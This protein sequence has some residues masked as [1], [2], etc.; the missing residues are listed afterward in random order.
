LNVGFFFYFFFSFPLRRLD[1]IELAPRVASFSSFFLFLLRTFFFFLSW[2]CSLCGARMWPEPWDRHVPFF[3]SFFSFGLAAQRL[4]KPDIVSTPSSP[5]RTG[6]FRSAAYACGLS[7]RDDVLFPSPSFFFMRRQS[8][9]TRR[10]S[11]PFPPRP[12]PSLR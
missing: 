8:K 10:P 9:R 4:G 5:M 2:V 7:D 11:P 12:Y 6:F 1:Q 3:F